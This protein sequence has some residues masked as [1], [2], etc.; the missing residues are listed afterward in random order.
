VLGA[1]NRPYDVDAA[2]LRRLPRSFEIGL[3]NLKSRDQILKLVLQKQP[4]TPDCRTYVK[5]ELPKLTEGYSGSDLKEL[6]RAA[7]MEPIRQVTMRSSRRAVGVGAG[8][9]AASDDEDD[10]ALD[11]KTSLIVGPEP[12]VPMRPVE[13]MDFVMALQKV[14][15][16]GETARAFLRKENSFADVGSGAAANSDSSLAHSMQLLQ[17]LLRGSINAAAAPIV[18]EASSNS[19]S[20]GDYDDIPNL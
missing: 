7:A 17:A 12:G 20:Y 1:T 11:F 4:M 8:A 16:T 2:I 18:E 15:R 10:S 19:T 3:P 9:E 13:E 14:K 5:E 6:C